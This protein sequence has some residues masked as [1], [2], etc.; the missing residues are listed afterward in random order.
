MSNNDNK[1]PKEIF[2]HFLAERSHK[3]LQAFLDNH[4]GEQRD[5]DFKRGWPELSCMA[6]HILGIANSGGGCIIIGVQE[7]EDK[8]FKLVGLESNCDKAKFCDGVYSFLP[9]RL[10]S[11]VS[12]ED[13]KIRNKKVQVVFVTSDPIQVPYISTDAGIG[14]ERNII[15]IRRQGMTNEANDEELQQLINKRIATG[16]SSSSEIAL[17]N[18]LEEL[19]ILYSEL[20]KW[21]SLPLNQQIALSIG[22]MGCDSYDRFLTDTIRIKCHKLQNL[23][24]NR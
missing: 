19:K 3:T 23:L 9:A 4:T 20:A 10:Q 8:A 15:Y 16:Y 11:N 22:L 14:I 12:L 6:K 21:K 2:S 24:I 5:C 7:Q 1:S 18:H 13:F 17:R